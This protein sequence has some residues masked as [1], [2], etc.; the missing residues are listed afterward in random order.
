[1]LAAEALLLIAKTLAE[2]GQLPP[3]RSRVNDAL[4]LLEGAEGTE[5]PRA[6]AL[7][8]LGELALKE[9]N[10]DEAIEHLEGSLELCEE[11]EIIDLAVKLAQQLV[12]AYTAVGDQ[13]SAEFYAKK[14]QQWA[15]TL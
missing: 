7:L 15:P 11:L 13:E 14:S 5:R 1:M 4:A 3:A 8:L 2:R 9:K 12:E 6:E 10:F